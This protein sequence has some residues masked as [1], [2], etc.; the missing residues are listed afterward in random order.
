MPM[1]N[2]GTTCH[3]TSSRA[4]QRRPLVWCKVPSRCKF[5]MSGLFQP[6]DVVP[7]N[8]QP[9]ETKATKKDEDECN[10]SRLLKSYG[11]VRPAG[12]APGK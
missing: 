7:Y 6:F 3:T 12:A 11:I 5:T 9:K 4:M 10:S 1:V 2:I 8:Q